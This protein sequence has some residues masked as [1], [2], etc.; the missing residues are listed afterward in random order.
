MYVNGAYSWP[1]DPAE[2]DVVWTVVTFHSRLH[3]SG[4]RKAGGNCV[5]KQPVGVEGGLN[6]AGDVTGGLN[7]GW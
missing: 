5:G 3:S 2:V 1:E 7:K 6:K 4:A